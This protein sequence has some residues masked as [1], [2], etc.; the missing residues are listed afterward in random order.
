MMREM[1]NNGRGRGLVPSKTWS[2]PENDKV[3]ILPIEEDCYRYVE[4]IADPQ[5]NE[6]EVSLVYRTIVSYLGEFNKE[7]NEA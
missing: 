7:E 2:F 4:V 1:I 3:R 5:K 6:K